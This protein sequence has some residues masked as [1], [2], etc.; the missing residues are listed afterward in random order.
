MHFIILYVINFS[1]V[2]TVLGN[3]TLNFIIKCQLCVGVR[4]LI[5]F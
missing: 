5:L 3:F 2:A 4:R 1:A